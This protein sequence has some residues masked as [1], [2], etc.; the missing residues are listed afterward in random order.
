MLILFDIPLY[1]DEERT[2]SRRSL[3]YCLV[4]S[5]N[6]WRELVKRWYVVPIKDNNLNRVSY[7]NCLQEPT[8]GQGETI[9]L[10]AF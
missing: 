6:A 7:R 3:I 4:C 9:K 2:K 8:T 5:R 10:L 1:R